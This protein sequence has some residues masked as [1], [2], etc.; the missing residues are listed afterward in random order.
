M[1]HHRRVLKL[2][3]LM[4]LLFLTVWMIGCAGDD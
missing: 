4:A 1:N 3:V 2:A